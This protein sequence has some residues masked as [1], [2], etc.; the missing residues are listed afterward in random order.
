MAARRSLPL[1]VALLFASASLSHTDA[2]SLAEADVLLRFKR[3]ITDPNGKLGNWVAGEK[4][5]GD[6]KGK[7]KWDGVICSDGNLHGL[8]LENMGLSGML[9]VSVGV[10][11]E[12][13][14]LRTLSFRDN[15]FS[16]PMPDVK[17]LAGLRSIYLSNNKL[18]GEIPEDAFQ[19][20]GSLKKVDLSH[21]DFS[22]PI[23]TSLARV[24]K[25]L[26]LRLDDNNFSGAIPD[27]RQKELQLLNV[28]HNELEGKIP[29]GLKNV[30][31]AF[32]DG[33]ISSLSL[34]LSK[35]CLL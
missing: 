19:G 7:G 2:A 33:L 31:E 1:L 21:N 24:L 27:L 8:Q 34:S 35:P 23:P 15:Q 18:S 30:K 10:L 22:G 3:M 14:D 26:Q 29:D 12:L 32:F 4:P 25:L 9:N 6:G 16:G 13:P 5:C 17:N 20:M 11:R 28:S